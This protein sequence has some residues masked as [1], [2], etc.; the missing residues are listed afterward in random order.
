MVKRVV[1]APLINN[2]LKGVIS[3][4]E[5]GLEKSVRAWTFYAG[6]LTFMRRHKGLA[7]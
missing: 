6:V 2:M 1:K 5:Q 4:Q 3:L 7:L